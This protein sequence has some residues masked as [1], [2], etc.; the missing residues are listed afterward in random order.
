MFVPMLIIQEN[1]YWEEDLPWPGDHTSGPRTFRCTASPVMESV[2][3]NTACY[4]ESWKYYH[5]KV[6]T[7]YNY[8]LSSPAPVLLRRT[9]RHDRTHKPTL[10]STCP[11]AWCMESPVWGAAR[12]HL[13]AW[14]L[15]AFPSQLVSE[16]LLGFYPSRVWYVSVSHRGDSVYRSVSGTLENNSW[17]WGAPRTQKSLCCCIPHGL[18][19]KPGHPLHTIQIWRKSIWQL[20]GKLDNRQKQLEY[21]WYLY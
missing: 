11:A 17:L 4:N 5:S 6:K 1:E 9:P 7:Y 10:V 21:R 3:A 12:H 8:M 15:V 14:G 19:F 16:A 2:R 20:L 18:Y 13:W